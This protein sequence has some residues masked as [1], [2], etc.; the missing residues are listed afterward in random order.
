MSKQKVWA[1]HES[2]QTDWIDR[3]QRIRKTHM[4]FQIRL[5][6]I[7]LCQD[8][9]FIHKNCKRIPG[10]NETYHCSIK[11]GEKLE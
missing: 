9:A 3:K 11:R 10:S 5:A 7:S 4:S 1:G 6:K 2:A 8:H